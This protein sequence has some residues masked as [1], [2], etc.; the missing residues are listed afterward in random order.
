M[1]KPTKV[2]VI[3]TEATDI[4]TDVVGDPEHQTGAVVQA[5]QIRSSILTPPYQNNWNALRLVRR[6]CGPYDGPASR[7]PTVTGD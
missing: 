6:L 5:H 4:Y 7:V 2:G 3:L 1:T